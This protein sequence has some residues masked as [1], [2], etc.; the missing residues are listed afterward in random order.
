MNTSEIEIATS[1]EDIAAALAAIFGGPVEGTVRLS[2]GASQE[3]WS[4][5]VPGRKEGSALIL[6]RG[7]GGVAKEGPTAVDAAM[8]ARILMA[9]ANAGVPVPSVVHVCSSEDRLGSGFIM[10]RID[11]ETIARKI[12]RDDE[13]AEAR[14][15]LAFHCGEAFA[16]IHKADLTDLKDLPNQ[17]AKSQ[18]D[19]Y[20]EIYKGFGEPHPVFELAFRWLRD[21]LPGEQ[22]GVLVHGDFRNGNII[23]DAKGLRSVLDWELAHVG[24]PMEDLGWISVNSWRFGEVHNPVGGF[25]SREDL[26]AGY[27][28]AGG[29]V[30]PKEV[31]FWEVFGTLKWGVICIIQV[32]AFK[33]G[34]DRSVE[35]AS[36]GR[37]ASETEIDL[38]NLL[39]GD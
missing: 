12:L 6:R 15:V 25:G 22:E 18:I 5:D 29:K 31:H 37:R 30:D 2:G 3:L 33:S 28:A 1:P 10:D 17:T 36:I 26:F 4:F 8:E 24:N 23:V 19:N 38:L 7:M 20:F 39:A 16:N 35:R 27:E 32:S 14:K 11:G 34:I 9:A 21:N 13:Y